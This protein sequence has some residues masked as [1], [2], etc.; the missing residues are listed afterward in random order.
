MLCGGQDSLSIMSD[1]QKTACRNNWNVGT[2]MKEK[3]SYKTCGD[4]LI[5]DIKPMHEGIIH[6]GEY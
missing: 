3:L 2:S 4:Y 6:S 1:N 5:P